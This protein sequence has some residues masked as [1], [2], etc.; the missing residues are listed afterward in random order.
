MNKFQQSEENRAHVLDQQVKEMQASLI[1]L[2]HERNDREKQVKTLQLDLE[3]LQSKQQEMLDENNELSVKVQQLE[4]E[5]LDTEQKLRDLRGCAD[6]QRQD[7]ANLQAQNVELE[8]LKL[9]LKQ[10][11]T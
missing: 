1:L 3:R 11:V 10:Y 8:Q 6:Q 4:R 7:A 2:K 9:Q 5:R